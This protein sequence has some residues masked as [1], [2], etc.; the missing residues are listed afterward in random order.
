[1]DTT[2]KAYLKDCVISPHSI[3][4]Q[5]TICFFV[6]GVMLAGIIKNDFIHNGRVEVLVH[7]ET[8][9]K[10]LITIPGKIIGDA[11]DIWIEKAR[12][13]FEKH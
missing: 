13:S 7:K 5:S 3:K 8:P 10:T 9:D 2:K 1:M 12:L 11:S 4:G 6:D